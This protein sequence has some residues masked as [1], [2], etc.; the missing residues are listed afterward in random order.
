M[1]H[2]QRRDRIRTLTRELAT[3][4]EEES[5]QRAV[6]CLTAQDIPAWLTEGLRAAIRRKITEET[7]AVH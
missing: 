7:P 2:E 3:L 6:R 5:P 4:I 1:T